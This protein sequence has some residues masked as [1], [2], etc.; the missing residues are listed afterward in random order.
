M[1]V[2]RIYSLKGSLTQAPRDGAS[3]GYQASHVIGASGEGPNVVFIFTGAAYHPNFFYQSKGR[4]QHRVGWILYF[5]NLYSRLVQRNYQQ[6]GMS[7]AFPF[8]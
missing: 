6:D 8:S 4:T 7:V 3:P 5:P 2:V 1:D